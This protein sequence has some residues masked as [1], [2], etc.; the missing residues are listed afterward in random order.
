MRITST[1]TLNGRTNES[2]IHTRS[3][4]ACQID[5]SRNI[6]DLW[7]EVF[8]KHSYRMHEFIKIPR[9]RFFNHCINP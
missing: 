3:A 4:N 5:S 6:A 1:L 2:F 9:N 7:H 8:D